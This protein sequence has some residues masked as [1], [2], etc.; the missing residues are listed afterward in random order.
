MQEEK[1]RLTQKVKCAGC[2]A[3]IPPE[4]LK[5]ALQGIVW[6]QVSSAQQVLVGFSGSDDAGVFKL[7]DDLALVQTTDF[8][9]PVVDDPFLYGQ[10]AATNALSDVYAMGGIPMSALNLVGYPIDLG[11]EILREILQGGNAALQKAD[12]ALLGGHSINISEMI[13]GLA[14]TG[15]IHPR[16]IKTNAHA[17]AGDVIILTKALGTGVLNTAIKRGN[18]NPEYYK[19]LIESMTRLNA[20]ASS[21]MLKYKTHACT[22]ITGF[23]LMGHAM[24]L[25]LASGVALKLSAQNLPLLKGATWA[26]QN[27][28]VTGG[29][30]ANRRYTEAFLRLHPELSPEITALLFDP[31]SSGGL[32]I[33][34]AEKEALL[35]EK[36]LRSAGDEKATIIG[37]VLPSSMD[38]PA[39]TIVVDL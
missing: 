10:I 16:D 36:T 27:E 1:I 17:Q 13:Y 18:L 5:E 20:S 35:L 25:A 12:C 21:L 11:A 24:Q 37:Q 33:C 8:F 15:K 38:K 30:Q 34:V 31:Q 6:P 23:G 19:G 39:G 28:F 9:P 22:D 3:K 14:V 4:L 7:S 29:A 32:F 2:A 26:V